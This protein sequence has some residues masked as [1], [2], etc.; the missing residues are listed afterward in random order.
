VEPMAARKQTKRRTLSLADGGVFHIGPGTV[1]VLVHTLPLDP[2]ALVLHINRSCG[3]L[4]LVPE[5]DGVALPPMRV[6]AARVLQMVNQINADRLTA[7]IRGGK[8]EPPVELPPTFKSTARHVHEWRQ[9][10]FPHIKISDEA[11][12]YPSKTNEDE[13]LFVKRATGACVLER[14][15]PPLHPKD[16]VRSVGWEEITPTRAVAWLEANGYTAIPATLH[17]AAKT[18]KGAKRDAPKK[19][20]R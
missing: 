10:V 4:E 19:R 18:G 8:M 20:T 11:V 1:S 9:T 17:R 7:A 12:G 2:P 14:T 6:D 16:V 5:A 13:T 15:D 3:A